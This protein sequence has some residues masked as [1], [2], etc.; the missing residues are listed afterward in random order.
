MGIWIVRRALK[1]G[2]VFSAAIG[3]AAFAVFGSSGR[4]AGGRTSLGI[5]GVLLLRTRSDDEREWS[6]NGEHRTSIEPLPT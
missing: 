2:L 6:R 5:G 1:L 4:P 3:I